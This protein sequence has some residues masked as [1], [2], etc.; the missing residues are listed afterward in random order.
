MILLKTIKIQVE[1][2]SPASAS[3]SPASKSLAAKNFHSLSNLSKHLDLVSE[4]CPQSGEIPW[5]VLP[6]VGDSISQVFPDYRETKEEGHSLDMQ[7]EALTRSVELVKQNVEKSDLRIFTLGENKKYKTAVS[8]SQAEVFYG[9][10]VDTFLLDRVGRTEMIS[11]MRGLARGEEHRRVMV[12]SSV[13]KSNRF[14]HFFA[15]NKLYLGQETLDR[16]CN[17]LCD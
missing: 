7:K 12:Q 6:P 16:L 13:G 8:D 9:G 14:T 4:F 3:R 2:G 11:G 10:L 1:G 17:A 15:Q 5:H